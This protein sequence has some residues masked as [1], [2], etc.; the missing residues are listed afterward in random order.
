MVLEMTQKKKTSQDQGDTEAV[1]GGE[2]KKNKTL[3]AR[4]RRQKSQ[5]DQTL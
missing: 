2:T 1:S 3:Q 5:G 4:K